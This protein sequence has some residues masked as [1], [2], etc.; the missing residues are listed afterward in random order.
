MAGFLLLPPQGGPANLEPSPSLRTHHEHFTL[1]SSSAAAFYSVHGLGDSHVAITRAHSFEPQTILDVSSPV[2]SLPTAAAPLVASIA[3]SLA[4]YASRDTETAQL[5]WNSVS[6]SY[7][8]MQP[9]VR[10][11][12]ADLASASTP[13]SLAIHIR[14]GASIRILMP[15]TSAPLLDLDLRTMTLA[16][17]ASAI[18]QLSPSTHTLDVL[19]SSLLALLI[20]LN[21]HT[22]LLAPPTIASVARVASPPASPDP[23]ML[24]FDPPPTPSR[25]PPS[26]AAKPAPTEPAATTARW[27]SLRRPLSSHPPTPRGGGPAIALHPRHPA[28][29]RFTPTLTQELDDSAEADADKDLEA[30]LPHSISKPIPPS[31]IAPEL[32]AST[33]GVDLSRFQAFDLEDP[34][35]GPGVRTALRVIY[36]LFGVLVWILGTVFSVLAAT[37]VSVGG[38]MGGKGLGKAG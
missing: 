11:Y 6:G 30:A 28:S 17:R 27:F 7:Y 23:T 21:R 16:V 3:P 22:A 25:R 20:H 14:A 9:C 37:V 26:R 2:L 18:T 31:G 12:P 38:C 5:L 36:W 8:V 35:L 34:N 32:R 13:T 4:E 15:A 1:T 19:A 29:N 10:Q 33:T 24:R